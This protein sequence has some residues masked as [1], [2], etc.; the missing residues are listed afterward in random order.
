MIA[1]RTIALPRAS[2]TAV[3]LVKRGF[4]FPLLLRSP[5]HHTGT[6]FAWV[7][8]ADELDDVRETLPGPELLAIEYLDGRGADGMYRK[9]RVLFI[10]GKLY[11]L[12]LAISPR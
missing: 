8:T 5:G 6:H 12:H 4:A 2:V 9:Y 11:P 1:P 3:E 10:G 7:E